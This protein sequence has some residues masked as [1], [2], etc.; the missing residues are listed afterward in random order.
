MYICFYGIVSYC[1]HIH[2]KNIKKKHKV[3]RYKVSR[4]INHR[5]WITFFS[6]INMYLIQGKNMDKYKCGY[7]VLMK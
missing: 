4:K 6:D 2:T 7:T 3:D 5:K 1:L